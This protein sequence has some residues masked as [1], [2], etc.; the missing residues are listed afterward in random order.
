M[1]EPLL[2]NAIPVAGAD[3]ESILRSITGWVTSLAGDE[4]HALQDRIDQ[5]QELHAILGRVSS[6]VEGLA[7]RSGD[8][9]EIDVTYN[10]DVEVGRVS[11]CPAYVDPQCVAALLY[12][13]CRI[14]T[15]FCIIP[16]C[17]QRLFARE[18][19]WDGWPAVA[20]RPL[21]RFVCCTATFYSTVKVTAGVQPDT[22]CCVGMIVSMQWR[23][24]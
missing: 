19:L 2:T 5:N 24:S 8:S 20:L 15:L 21:I 13:Q 14:V 17:L 4:D 3:I 16:C 18:Q 11:P 22:S 9:V 6:L 7:G 10:L 1:H 23:Q 12:L